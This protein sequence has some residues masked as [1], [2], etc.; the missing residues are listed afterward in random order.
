MAKGHC[1]CASALLKAR[2]PGPAGGVVGGVLV[3]WG[4]C[5]LQALSHDAQA[6]KGCITMDEQAHHLLPGCVLQAGLL[7]PHHPQHHRANE[8]QVTGV[9]RNAEAHGRRPF[10]ILSVHTLFWM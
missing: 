10:A 6:C 9:G 5:K 8:L 1:L 3:T 2:K 4:V 7:C